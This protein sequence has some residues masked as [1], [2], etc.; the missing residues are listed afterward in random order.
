[1]RVFCKRV[2]P[3]LQLTKPWPRWLEQLCSS[4]WMQR[5]HCMKILRSWPPS[6]PLLV[7]S[8]STDYHSASAVPPS[9]FNAGWVQSWLD[10]K[11]YCATRRTFSSLDVI[12]VNTTPDCLLHLAPFQT[13]DSL[14]TLGWLAIPLL[15]ARHDNCAGTRSSVWKCKCHTFAE[16]CPADLLVWSIYSAVSMMVSAEAC[17]A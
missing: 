9:I 14:S 13:L 12:R 10:T 8:T 16:T 15:P 17:C 7:V 2:T 1:M 6:S 4:N 11:V 3:D 5:M